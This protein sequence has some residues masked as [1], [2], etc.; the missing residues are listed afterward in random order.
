MFKLIE[1]I[2]NVR[3][4]KV[5]DD[6]FLYLTNEGELYKNNVIFQDNVDI[7][8]PYEFLNSNTFYFKAKNLFHNN[9]II[10]D[11][12]FIQG[13]FEEQSDTILVLSLIHI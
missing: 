4:F 7:N 8:Y 9:K 2:E 1:K 3:S 5:Y 11:Q 12:P 13:S 6:C 10:S